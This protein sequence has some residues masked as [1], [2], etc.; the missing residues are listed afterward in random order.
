MPDLFVFG[1]LCHSPLLSIVLGRD[2]VCLPATLDGFA[3]GCDSG[4]PAETVLR[5]EARAKAEGL[6]IPDVPEE[7][8]ARLDY[9][10][11]G[12]AD[13][14]RELDVRLGKGTLRAL[15]AVTEPAPEAAPFS[16]EGWTAEWGKLACATAREV[17]ARFG[18]AP[19]DETAALRSFIA[20]R[21]WAQILAQNSAPHTLR[22][23]R[24]RDTVELV[25]ERPGF[26]GFFRM[27]AFDLRHQRFDG[28][29]SETFG[30]ESFVTYDAALVL[31]YDPETDRVLLVEQLRYGT[32]MRGDPFP[33]VLEPPAGLVDAGE[34]PETCAL[35]EAREEAG[36]DIRELRPIMGGYASPGYTTEFYH[37]FLGICSLSAADNGLSGLDEEH[38]DIRNHVISFDHAMALVDSGEINVV[39]LAGMLLWLARHRDAIRAQS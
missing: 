29:M 8:L 37:C 7:E 18:K 32:Y 34:T 3:V 24:G 16:L 12:T 39:P 36:L 20:A 13:G 27:R 11:A 19:R 6:L 25:R 26:E 4:A 10:L 23:G 33:S 21:A 28:A 30:R 5:P 1:T 2:P 15:V 31:P 9:W 38:E 14:F 17:M 22:S 35:R